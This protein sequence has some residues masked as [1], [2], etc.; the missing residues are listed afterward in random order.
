MKFE[1]FVAVEESSDMLPIRLLI[2]PFV[3]TFQGGAA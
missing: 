3:N 2:L 1:K